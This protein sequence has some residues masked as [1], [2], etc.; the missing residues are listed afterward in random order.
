MKLIW[1]LLLTFTLPVLA[2]ASG[3]QSK[4]HTVDGFQNYP[5]TPAMPPLGIGFYLR[6]A[7]S[8]FFLPDVPGDHFL[9]G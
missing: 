4:H 2:E 7:W 3:D 9:V 8:S 1:I 5:I 6:R